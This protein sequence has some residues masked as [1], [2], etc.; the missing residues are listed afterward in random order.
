MLSVDPIG[1]A[2]V[3]TAKPVTEKGASGIVSKASRAVFSS[4][5]FAK[6]EYAPMGIAN[7][8]A[9]LRRVL[10]F[11]DHFVVRCIEMPCT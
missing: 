4:N 2:S 11:F 7:L 6:I 9:A 5:S 8:Q 3:L 10:V 1:I